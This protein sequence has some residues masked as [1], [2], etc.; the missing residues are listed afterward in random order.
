VTISDEAH[1]FKAALATGRPAL[2]QTYEALRP[3][4]RLD[5]DAEV[6]DRGPQDLDVAVTVHGPSIRP[7]FFDYSLDDLQGWLRYAD[8]QVALNGVWGRHGVGV[9]GIKKGVVLLGRNGGYQVRLDNPADPPLVG[10]G[11][12]PDDDL[13]RALP[14]AL[15]KGFNSVALRGPVD[16]A[17]S[18][19]VTVAEPGASPEIWWDGQAHLDGNALHAGVEVSEAA[20]VVACAGNFKNQQLDWVKG[21]IALE[22]ATVLGQPLRDLHAQL[23]AEQKHPDELRFHNIHAD[24]FGGSLGGEARLTFGPA[25]SYDVD[26]L[27]L[28]VRLEQFGRHNF[29]AAELQGAALVRLYLAGDGS[30]VSG[31]HGG[32]LIEVPSGKMLRLPPLL[33]L[34]NAFGLR[35][36]D[37]TAF[38][39]AR[40]RFAVDG[41][42]M[43]VDEMELTGNAVSLSG[44]GTL[45]LDGSNLNLD[46]AA[47]WGRVRSWLPRGF[48]EVPR[49][50]SEQF[51][52]IKMRGK[53]GEVHYDPVIVPGVAESVKSVL[54]RN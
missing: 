33:G 34:L 46:F 30:G 21:N 47:T 25:F 32:G 8:G 39:Q 12:A 18:L 36:P 1:E 42:Q 35:A 22:Q 24:L 5:F 6:L 44:Q 4:G 20:G 11:L 51:F 10:R 45:N 49:L 38:E 28:G 13:Q 17:S 16:V 41:P 54:G 15:K 53:V 40:L 29:P 14:A 27:A 9:L 23:E 52:K 37:K 26:L 31:L 50:V 2:G 19:I 7:R 3:G 48:N 43:R